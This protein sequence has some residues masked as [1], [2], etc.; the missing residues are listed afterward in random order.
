MHRN[1][2]LTVDGVLIEEGKI[3]LIRRGREP[4]KGKWALP[5]GFVEYGE[6]VEDA[7]IREF[8][9]ETGLDAEIIK[10]LGVYSDPNRDP[11]GHTVSIVYMLKRKGGE[12]KEGDDAAEVGFFPLDSLPELAFDHGKII[13]DAIKNQI[14]KSNR[15]ED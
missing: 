15:F 9:E 4:F 3:L 11:R 1:P 14:K 5:G 13:E 12:L 10:L 2:A 8:K 6:S 7:V